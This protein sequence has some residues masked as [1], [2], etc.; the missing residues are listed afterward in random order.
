MI[1]IV[2]IGAV[3]FIDEK[4]SN[5]GTQT[6]TNRHKLFEKIKLEQS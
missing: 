5:I 1:K 6:R 4:F 3:D 2:N